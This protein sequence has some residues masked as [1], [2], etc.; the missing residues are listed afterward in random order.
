MVYSDHMNTRPE[1]IYTKGCSEIV[2][3]SANVRSI[4]APYGPL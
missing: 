2:M 3:R 1:N 4:E